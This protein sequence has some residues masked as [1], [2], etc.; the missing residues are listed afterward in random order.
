M[1]CERE[2]FE[3]A[4]EDVKQFNWEIS[5]PKNPPTVLCAGVRLE[6]NKAS[7]LSVEKWQNGLQAIWKAY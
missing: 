7:Q 2:R 3:V 5:P 4:I 6:A 1:E